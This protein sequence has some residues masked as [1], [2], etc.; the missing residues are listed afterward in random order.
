MIKEQ[1]EGALTSDFGREQRSLHEFARLTSKRCHG[2]PAASL[3][4]LLLLSP[5]LHEPAKL[6]ARWQRAP[7]SQL[8]LRAFS[9]RALRAPRPLSHASPATNISCAAVAA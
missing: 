9:A 5:L 8:H 6:A 1:S 2:L 7:R 4:M 3:L